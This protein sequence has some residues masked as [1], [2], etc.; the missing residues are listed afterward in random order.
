MFTEV[1]NH[2]LLS[3]LDLS[4]LCCSIRSPGWGPGEESLIS[5]FSKSYICTGD[6][7]LSVYSSCHDISTPVS[8][9]QVQVLHYVWHIMWFDSDHRLFVFFFKQLHHSDTRYSFNQ[10]W[11]PMFAP[12]TVTLGLSTTPRKQ[13]HQSAKIKMHEELHLRSQWL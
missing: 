13:I 10:I 11:F 9:F 6:T 1:Q 7:I 4:D 8:S 5:L 2:R 12:N 3:S